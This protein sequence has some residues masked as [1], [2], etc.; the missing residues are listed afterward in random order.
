M[1]FI[2]RIADAMT[3]VTTT[4]DLKDLVGTAEVPQ[5]VGF[6]FW[7]ATAG[8]VSA[9]AVNCEMFWTDIQ[10]QTRTIGGA[11]RSLQ[12]ATSGFESPL[13]LMTRA[14][15]DSPVDFVM[16]LAGVDDGAEVRYAILMSSGVSANNSPF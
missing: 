2:Y 1:A 16:T 12:D 8:G 10:G 4:I 7:V 6:S 9:G 3:P 5:F 14:A 11:P 13:A 15:A